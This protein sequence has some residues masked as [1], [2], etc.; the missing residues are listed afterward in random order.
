[1]TGWIAQDY[2]SAEEADTRQN[3]LDNSTDCI[4]VYGHGNIRRPERNQRSNGS[5][6]SDQ[7]MRSESCRLSV[8]FTVQTEGTSK[9]QR[10]AKAKGDFFIS[11]EHS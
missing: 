6:K 11:A 3:A 7:R 8:Q 10:C 9:N 5:P 1:V 2:P 4:L